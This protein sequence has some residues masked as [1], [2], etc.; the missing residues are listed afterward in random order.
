[1]RQ[2][3]SWITDR[4]QNVVVS[5][6]SSP[7]NKFQAGLGLSFA[8]PHVFFIINL[9]DNVKGHWQRALIPSFGG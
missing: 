7:N 2:I 4:S 6:D 9:E 8:L 3:E 5:E 1:M